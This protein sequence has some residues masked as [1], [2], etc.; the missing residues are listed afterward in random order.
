MAQ[1]LMPEGQWLSLHP[2][3]FFHRFLLIKTEEKSPQVLEVPPWVRVE[4]EEGSKARRLCEAISI[5]YP[6]PAVKGSSDS[7]LGVALGGNSPH[8]V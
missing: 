3:Y 2:W 1:A 7:A 8:H 6:H 4:V 5:P